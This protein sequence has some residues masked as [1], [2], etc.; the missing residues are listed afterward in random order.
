MAQINDPAV[1]QQIL[2]FVDEETID[3][4]GI[5][6]ILSQYQSGD[7]LQSDTEKLSTGIYKHFNRFDILG[8][9]SHLTITG[10]WTGDVHLLDADHM[11]TSSEE[12]SGS[13]A[14]YY[15]NIYN[16]D[17]ELD[18]E[19]SGSSELQFA[20]AYG[21]VD[22]SGSAVLSREYED[23]L[24]CSKANYSYYR[25]L[26]LEPD[27][28]KFRFENQDGIQIESDSIYAITLSRALYRDRLQSDGWQL[29]LDKVLDDDRPKVIGFE[30]LDNIEVP[31]STSFEDIPHHKYVRLILSNGVRPTVRII[32][33]EWDNDDYDP[34]TPGDYLVYNSSF[35]ISDMPGLD[36][37]SSFDRI[38]YTASVQGLTFEYLPIPPVY[39]PYETPI[40]EIPHY[41]GSV[42]IILSTGESDTIPQ[43]N[44][45]T[46]SANI[47]YNNNVPGTY[48]F[49]S[50]DYTLPEGVATPI[51]IEY[52]VIVL[53][54]NPSEFEI[55]YETDNEITFYYSGSWQTFGIV[56][57][58][59]GTKWLDRNLGASRVAQSVDDEEA[60]G[61]L[62][63]WGRFRDGHERRD[64]ETTQSFSDSID[65]EHDKF[66][67]YSDSMNWLVPENRNLWQSN[68]RINIPAPSGWSI[69]TR[70][71]FNDER[72]SWEDSY[73]QYGFESELKLTTCGS[74]LRDTGVVTNNPTLYWTSTTEGA[75]NVRAL[76]EFTGGTTNLSGASPGRGAAVRL[77]KTPP[78]PQHDFQILEETNDFITFG[79]DGR[80]VTY[81]IV[82]GANGTKWMD[83]NL[84]ALR[85]ARSTNDEE[86]FGDYYQWGRLKD[87]HQRFN[88]GTRSTQS[89]SNR[90]NHGDFIINN[91]DWRNPR[92]DQL[93]KNRL[94]VPAPEGWRLPTSDE[95]NNE[96]NNWSNNTGT[97]AWNSPLKWTMSGVRSS[98]GNYMNRGELGT[99][100][101]SDISTNT[102][103]FSMYFTESDA[104]ILDT[105]RAAG[106]PIRLI[107]D[108]Q[109]NMMTFGGLYK[110]SPT[111][112][113]YSP[114][115]Y[116][117]IDDS[118]IDPD[119][120][121]Y[122]VV[123]GGLQIGHSSGS[124]ITSTA[125]D[126]EGHG[127]G[128]FYPNH[129]IIILNPLAISDKIDDPLLQ[130]FTNNTAE[131]R[132]QQY[133]VSSI[134][135]GDSFIAIRREDI[136]YREFL[137]WVT[138]REFNYSHNPTYLTGGRFTVED[139]ERNPKTYITTIGLYNDENEL[140]AVAKTSK[141][142]EKSF[143][144]EVLIKVRLL[145]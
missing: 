29:S 83:R 112:N 139:F 68:S 56:R 115:A 13:S 73:I 113:T 114:P 57:G 133:L 45:W 119:K 43:I 30:P 132:N 21:H 82:T 5:R 100:F 4:D 93:W 102:R 95:L 138:N 32:D 59:N 46:S 79:Y 9:K 52:N 94:N 25:S 85:V 120:D 71:Q 142:I 96:I 26:L 129:G 144:K 33:S 49:Y 67:A 66:I 99:I 22:G 86:A 47:P 121:V 78:P 70:E 14:D 87:G 75:N 116:T 2:G 54:D 130:G 111:E 55:A 136:S 63:Q 105:N 17:V 101:S 6:E 124:F 1:I 65:P 24:L 80:W 28:P 140:L 141:P 122:K 18:H 35:D 97:A 91:L 62:Y 98:D 50:F 110:T 3:T 60:F 103:A 84:G 61:D 125:S 143:E 134:R 23:S 109:S 90:P 53:T 126:N 39:V 69:P 41:T 38:E 15:Y 131:Q 20:V 27:V 118:S 104:S 31:F 92:N 51:P 123:E 137:V 58:Q 37:T 106:L 7:V 40:D 128:L 34:E 127:Y 16:G 77:V 74:R 8:G 48:P 36:T 76:A 108:T 19:M 107:K 12:L 10:V 81:G 72:V 42:E 117:F 88:S 44:S 145:F 11:H 135:A 89:T 64:S